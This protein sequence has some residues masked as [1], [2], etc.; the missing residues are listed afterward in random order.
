MTKLI[1]P[2]LILKLKK[3]A[4]DDVRYETRNSRRFLHYIRTIE[5]SKTIVS[6]YLKVIYLPGVF[7]DTEE[8]FSKEDLLE[9]YKTFTEKDLLTYISNGNWDR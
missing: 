5:W 2:T 3:N 8:I 9:T 4:L 7:N 6:A 1:R